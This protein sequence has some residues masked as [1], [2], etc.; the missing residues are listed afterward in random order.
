MDAAGAEGPGT[1]LAGTYLTA[2]RTLLA[3]QGP[4]TDET[5]N[6]LANL[7][8]ERVRLAPSKKRATTVRTH[9]AT[10]GNPA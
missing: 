1:R 8:A 10:K 6:T 2:L 3:R 4:S 5:T 7:R 9:P